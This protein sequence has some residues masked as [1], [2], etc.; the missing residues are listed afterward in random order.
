MGMNTRYYTQYHSHANTIAVCVNHLKRL[1]IS[2]H[3]PDFH[4]Y[5]APIPKLIDPHLPNRV[6]ESATYTHTSLQYIYTST[7]REVV[8]FWGFD[9]N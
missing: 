3:T 1:F 8:F 9:I 7:E 5:H 4:N 2:K 6:L